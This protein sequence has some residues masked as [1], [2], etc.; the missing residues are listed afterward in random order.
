VQ[1]QKNSVVAASFTFD[2]DGKRV[3]SVM[4]ADTILF[5][6][7]HYEIKNGNQI[8]QY[9]MAGS[10]RIAM[11]KYTIPQ[12]MTLEYMLSDHLGSTSLTTDAS[13]AKVLELRYK[14]WGEIRAT[15]TSSPSTTPAY[16]SPAY[17]Y[18]GQYSYMDDPTTSGVTEGFGLMFYNARWY[19]PALGRFAQADTI[20]PGG[21]QG[22]DRY[23]YVNNSPIRY[24][25]PSGHDP[26]NNDCDYA[27][28]CFKGQPLHLNPGGR[29]AWEILHQKG[30]YDDT[31]KALEYLIRLEFGW[32]NINQ[33]TG[34]ANSGSQGNATFQGVTNRYQ[35]YCTDPNTGGA[36]SGACL[37]NFWGY[38]Q[39]FIGGGG[40]PDTYKDSEPLCGGCNQNTIITNIASAIQHPGQTFGAGTSEEVTASTNWNGGCDDPYSS[41][42]CQYGNARPDMYTTFFPKIAPS[43]SY[44]NGNQVI[45]AFNVDAT[46]GSAYVALSNAMKTALS[47]TTDIKSFYYCGAHCFYG[48]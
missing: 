10:T 20:V 38:H 8:T 5:V 6:G 46:D 19:D 40:D 26:S 33:N 43:Y 11:R 18:T 32:A 17:T 42:I 35:T 23:A 36:F 9:Y 7:A 27:G 21:V 3:K 47:T 34:N 31:Q 29:R 45:Y 16:K 48:Q 14:A 28:Y 12:N 30:Y 1:V 24:I 13:G 2:A 39:T 22:L 25:D 44:V 4:G 15:W 37:N 41:N